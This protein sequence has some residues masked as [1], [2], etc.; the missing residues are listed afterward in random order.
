MEHKRIC[1]LDYWLQLE[2]NS[3]TSKQANRA[4]HLHFLVVLQTNA[5]AAVEFVP[6]SQRWAFRVRQVTMHEGLGDIGGEM[7]VAMSREI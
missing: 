6:A 4:C 1:V 7:T 2:G 3:Q 5:S